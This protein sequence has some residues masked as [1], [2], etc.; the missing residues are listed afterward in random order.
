M[1][2]SSAALVVFDLDDTLYL[3]TDFVRSG[4]AAVEDALV[5]E[6]LAATAWALHEG[7]LRGSVLGEALRRHGREAT[8]DEVTRAVAIYRAHLP[9]I[10]VMPDAAAALASLAPDPSF[11]LALISDGL[12]KTQRNKIE[13]LRVSRWIRRIVLTDELAPDRACWKPHPA[14]FR[15]LQAAREC[16]AVR[17]YVADNPCKDFDAPVQLGWHT[18]RL[19]RPGGL[20]EHEPDGAARPAVTLRDLSRL[21][22][23]LRVVVQS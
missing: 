15:R 23:H 17:V 4:F 6:G 19:R 7:G 14:A 2:P 11:E 18:V 16:P 5:I 3:E 22:D 1:R 9:R 12:A 13:A 21:S 10:D 8:S 20:W